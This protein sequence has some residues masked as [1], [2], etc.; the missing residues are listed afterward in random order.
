MLSRF[1]REGGFLVS[2][3]VSKHTI[4]TGH[5]QNIVKRFEIVGR[6]VACFPNATLHLHVEDCNQKVMCKCLIL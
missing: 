3:L 4:N 6:Y 5:A 2:G 1:C